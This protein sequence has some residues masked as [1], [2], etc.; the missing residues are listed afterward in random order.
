MAGFITTRKD[1][2]SYSNTNR[3]SKL[4]R[5]ISNLGMDFDGKV[6]KNSR[7]IGLYDKDPNTSTSGNEFKFEDSVYDIFD[8]YSLTDPSMHKNVS[9]Y[10]RRYDEQKR[11]ELRRFA[12]QDE[13]E[14]ILDIITDETI[15]YNENGL[16]CELLYNN[17]LLT[18]DLNDE[19]NDIFNQIY[20]CFGFWDQNMAWGYF[21]KFLIEGFLAFEIIYDGDQ[22]HRETQKNI[23]K[24]KELEVLSLVPAVDHS[25]GEKIWIQYP[26]DPAKQRVLYDSQIIYISYAQFDSASR[27]SYVERLSRSFNLL[28]IME[29]TRIMWAVTN[30]SFKTTFTIP[31]ENHQNRGKQTL[32]ET[33]HSYREVID[34]NNE[35]G[36]IMVN[37]RPMLPFNKEYWFPSVNG[38][39]PQVQTLG[40]DGPDLSDTEAMNY[41][42]QKLWQASKIPFTRFDHMQGRGQYVLSTES[43]MRE[44]LKFRNFI[45]RLRSIYKELIVKP[46]YIQLCLKHKE[47][48][49]DVQFR[50]SLTLSFISDNVFTEMREIE[51]IQKK[52][53]FIGML[54]Q[55]IAETDADGNQVPYFDLD[56]LVS[57]FSGMTQEDL[58]ANAKMKEKKQ[59]EKDGYKPEDIEKILDGEP[60][61]RFKPEKKK[62]DDEGDEGGNDEGP[63][64]SL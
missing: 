52:T 37:G 41:F 3:V 24:F 34:F 53:D 39:S 50:N 6:F 25:T 32:A 28:R 16:F 19:I 29:S 5:K 13:I 46:V 57:R 45:N 27:I 31:V 55:N 23:I 35:S 1:P 7:A 44:E 30:S 51:V 10:D 9:L 62:K 15:C 18:D 11:N 61:S 20:S 48:A 12:M 21:R 22:E 56:F 14:D 8:G 64:L 58:D 33:M 49:T 59:L 40:G 43:M 60:K 38:E 47:F 54:M 2:R 17:T 4:L 63:G 36:E 42:K 26:N